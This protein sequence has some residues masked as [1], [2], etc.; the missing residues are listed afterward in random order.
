MLAG[1]R[2]DGVSDATAA[3]PL[4]DDARGPAVRH[5]TERCLQAAPNLTAIRVSS[6]PQVKQVFSFAGE[7][8]S[9]RY[10]QG[11]AITEGL[12]LVYETR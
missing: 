8:V 9:W 10:L 2:S 11:Q 6:C 5:E 12:A 1:P 4:P 7:I 3:A